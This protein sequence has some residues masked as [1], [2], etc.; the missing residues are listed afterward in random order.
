MQQSMGEKQD[1]EWLATAEK[2]LQ[3]RAS[4]MF[5]NI[6]E[7]VE[8]EC[9]I[10][11]AEIRVTGEPGVSEPLPGVANCNLLLVVAKRRD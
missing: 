6:I 9:G 5:A 4:P 11:I 3:E 7:T 8:R 2:M 10:D 1:F